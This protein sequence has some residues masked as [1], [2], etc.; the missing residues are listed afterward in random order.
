MKVRSIPP[1]TLHIPGWRGNIPEMQ[2]QAH[3]KAVDVVYLDFSKAFDTVFHSILTAKPR[4]CGLDDR[5]VRWT[6]N[7]L[8]GR[9]QRV[10]VNGMESSG[11]P[12]SRG[13]PQGS[14]LG[15]VLFNIVIS[16]SDEGMERAV[17]KFADDTKL[18][19]V[20]DTPEGSAAIQQDL[21]RLERWAGRNLLKYNEG[22]CRVLH[23]GKNNPRHQHKLGTALL[24]SSEGERDLGSWWT[25]G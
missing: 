23:Q 9:S 2:E 24:E 7:G 5:V 1:T 4:K 14:G 6:V 18:G 20:A 16:D 17:S 15:P 8:K 19:G 21:S 10:V 13:V 3:G 11:S 22:K 25:A 12:V